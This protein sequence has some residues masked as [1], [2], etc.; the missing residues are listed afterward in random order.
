MHFMQSYG[1]A[2]EF[3]NLKGFLEYFE[4]SSNNLQYYIN[5]IPDFERYCY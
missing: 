2:R 5:R 4:R 1:N 3:E